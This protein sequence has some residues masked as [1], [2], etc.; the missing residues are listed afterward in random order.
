MTRK[1]AG[2]AFTP[3]PSFLA[4]GIG[5]AVDPAHRLLFLAE[6]NGSAM[7]SAIMPFAA[8]NEVRRG[9]ANNSGFYDYYVELNL[10]DAKKSS[11]RL[12]CGDNPALADAVEKA[13]TPVLP[14]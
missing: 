6:P 1:T 12:L 14:A 3:G 9:E 8:I 5:L 11:W 4:Q 13:L 10:R 7:N 2:T